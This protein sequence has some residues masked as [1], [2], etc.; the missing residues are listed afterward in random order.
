MEQIREL[1][2]FCRA[3]QKEA[4]EVANGGY[5][6]A[7]AYVEYLTSNRAFCC[8]CDCSISYGIQPGKEIGELKIVDDSFDFVRY[9]TSFR[10]DYQL[11]LFNVDGLNDLTIKG[12]DSA[13]KGIGDYCVR[14]TSISK[15]KQKN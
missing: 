7:N 8:C 11:F 9:Y 14:V 10:T 15:Y 3:H 5:F 1:M 6:Y 12:N 13:G 2:D 4:T